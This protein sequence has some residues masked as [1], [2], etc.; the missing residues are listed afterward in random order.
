MV[1]PGAIRAIMQ[2][3]MQSV[4]GGNRPNVPNVPGP[5][6]PEMVMQAMQS[7]GGGG[8]AQQMLDQSGQQ[9]PQGEGD[10]TDNQ[11]PTDE[12]ELESVRQ[13][14]TKPDPQQLEEELRQCLQDDD[15]KGCEAILKEME[16]AGISI[17]KLSPDIQK[18]LETQG[19]LDDQGGDN[20]DSGNDD[21]EYNE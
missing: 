19:Y 12:E 2:Q 6:T 11:K 20:Q 16:D 4:Q 17:D 7:G 5:V 13:D 14:M 3:M 21:Q 9:M 15:R 8:A 10:S 1:D 18:Q